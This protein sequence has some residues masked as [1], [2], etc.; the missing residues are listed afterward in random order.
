MYYGGCGNGERL[1]I[2]RKLSGTGKETQ[3]NMADG[4]DKTV[5]PGKV[6]NMS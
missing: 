6:Y 1:G 2:S 5:L 3:S 4:E